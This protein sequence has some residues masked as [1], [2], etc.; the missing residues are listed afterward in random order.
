V[1]VCADAV[2]TRLAPDPDSVLRTAFDGT[3]ITSAGNVNWALLDDRR[4]NRAMGA[5]ALLPAGAD[6]L[7]A[8]ADVDRAI[9][10]TAPA[11]PYMWDDATLVQS[12]DVDGA[13]NELTGGWD[14]SFTRLR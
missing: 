10:R 1:A 9:V 11:I 5:A 13:V 4:I 2:S 14:L 8:W 6:R 3:R 7:S 12:A